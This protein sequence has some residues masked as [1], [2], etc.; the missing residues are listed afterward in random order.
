MF[1]VD[2]EQVENIYNTLKDITINSFEG[3]T[4]IDPAIDL[5]D[6]IIVDDKPVVFQGE[7]RFQT[8]FIADIKSTIS[9]KAKE[10]TTVRTT[11]QKVINRRIQS[12][13][14]QEDAKITLLAE[15]NTEN[16]E[17]ITQL[18]LGLDGITAT[19][20]DNKEEINEALETTRTELETQIQVSAEGVESNVS[21]TLESY[22]TTEE[23]NQSI[24]NAKT[25]A[26]NSANTSTDNKLKN[27]STTTQMNSAINQK[28]DEIS[29]SVSE[30]YITKTDSASN[31]ATAKTEAINSANT[32][33]DNKLKN[34]STTAQVDSKITQKANEI[35]T[36][37]SEAY[38]TK[39]DSATNISNAKSEAISTAGTNTDNKL[40]NY[41]TTTEM[42]SAITQKA[43]EITSTVSATYSTKTDTTNAINNINIGGRNLF[44]N[45][46][47][48]SLIGSDYPNN[49]TRTAGKIVVTAS[50]KFNA[51][52]SAQSYLTKTVAEL[53][54]V[55]GKE[56]T[57]SVEIKTTNL[58]TN[59]VQIGFDFR[60]GSDIQVVN[61]N[62]LPNKNGKWQKVSGNLKISRTDSTSAL[63][64]IKS[65]ETN[66]ENVVIEYRNFKL[67]EGNKATDWTPAPE[68]ATN[69]T[70]TK[71]TT[72]KSEI[73]QTTDSISLE[74]EGKL[75]ETKFTGG[76]IMLAINNDT[77][78]AQ[79][80]A[81]KIS[82]ERKRN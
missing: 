81:D 28:A 14:D 76:N 44:K 24:S 3:T 15:Q 49:S 70:D 10:E 37:V 27:Y 48:I 39:T 66:L 18:E 46:N 36:S 32:S 47:N 21:K 53:V 7:M 4:I 2:E 54:S 20:A 16:E 9:I 56:Y 72:A 43:N 33:T 57:F 29:T 62:I 17:K 11:S 73:K 68:D 60:K 69:Y 42:N 74:V 80:N 61:M 5:G 41:S 1:I 38:I 52:S 22:S 51:Y 25:E 55:I 6:K 78:T 13:I 40:K 50:A 71:I 23:T 58:T 19:V 67:E 30:S 12:R 34:Y 82:L 64:N 65:S 79:I 8:R 59:G 26:I 75:D 77:S 63:I 31:I 45:S 35:T